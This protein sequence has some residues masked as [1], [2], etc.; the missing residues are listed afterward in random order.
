MGGVKPIDVKPLPTPAP[1][2]CVK[3]VRSPAPPNEGGVNLVAP[4]PYVER[5]TQRVSAC[6]KVSRG[7]L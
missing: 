6:E 3:E 7:H 2:P 4:A 5:E 1:L